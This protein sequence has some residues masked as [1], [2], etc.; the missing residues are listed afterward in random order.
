MCQG[1]VPELCLRRREVPGQHSTNPWIIPQSLPS[2]VH[3]WGPRVLLGVLL[4]WQPHCP[5][6]SPCE[7]PLTDFSP[8]S[9]L[10][11][12]GSSPRKT[13]APKSLA[14]GAAWGNQTSQGVEGA[15]AERDK[16]SLGCKE[17][18]A[19][20]SGRRCFGRKHGSEGKGHCAEVR[21]R[22]RVCL[23]SSEGLARCLG[24]L[25]EEQGW[26]RGQRQTGGPWR[27]WPGFWSLI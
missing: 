4:G 1:L 24:C 27:L 15:S 25:E 3:F 22:R 7:Q 18:M 10:T 17:G 11:A 12:L 14:L 19:K 8:F 13:A 5:L 23:G 2:L 26:G 20:A 9:S 16:F 21:G 6:R